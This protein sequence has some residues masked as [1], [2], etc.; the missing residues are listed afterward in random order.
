MQVDESLKHVATVCQN[1]KGTFQEHQILQTALR[2]IQD[3]L[4]KVPIPSIEE[5][6]GGKLKEVKDV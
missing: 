2:T 1:Y 3:E 5:V 4:K 6:T